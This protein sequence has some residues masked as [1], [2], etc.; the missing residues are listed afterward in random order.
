MTAV[1]W[2]P[3]L[4]LRRLTVL[5]VL[6]RPRAARALALLA[7]EA[8][9]YEHACDVVVRACATVHYSPSWRR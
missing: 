5:R 2:H 3:P 9:T 6:L 4:R 7:D 8:A 1:K